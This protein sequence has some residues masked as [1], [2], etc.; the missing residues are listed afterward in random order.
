MSWP[1]R[2]GLV[3]VS[4]HQ[5]PC[6][7]H[8]ALGSHPAASWSAPA[9]LTTGL[10]LQMYFSTCCILFSSLA[11]LPRIR[12]ALV[13]VT[14][15]DQFGDP[16][17]G[18]VIQYNP[19]EAW[20]PGQTCSGCTAKPAPA[21]NAHNGTWTDAT[22]FPAGTGIGTTNVSGQIISASVPFV[23]TAVYVSVILTGSITSPDG[24]SDFTFL[25]D[26]ATAG[27]FQKEPNGDSS[28]QFNQIVFSQTGLENQLHTITIQSGNGGKKSIVLLDSIIYTK[29]NASGTDSNQSPSATQTPDSSSTGSKSSNVGV[30]VGPVVGGV[31]VGGAIIALIFFLRR[32]RRQQQQQGQNVRVL[33]DSPPTPAMRRDP[34]G[35]GF[36]NA[37]SH[38]EPFVT[39]GSQTPYKHNNGSYVIA[40][41]EYG[42][43]AVTGTH[44]QRGHSPP[45]HPGSSEGGESIH[46]VAQPRTG[47]S[48]Y[49]DVD[50]SA[51]DSTTPLASPPAYSEVATSGSSAVSRLPNPYGKGNRVSNA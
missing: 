16:T 11:L 33:I 43:T 8:L 3:L 4:S 22:F 51:I 25:I 7:E 24:R 47:A 37:M 5:L 30:I 10:A 49:G 23:G 1:R 45:T 18:Q 20:N 26:N 38:V 19:P 35:T 27:V 42:G 17:T 29:K 21:S 48:A 28:Y 15:D 34:A 44:I 50:E 12:G 31:I 2:R 14:I 39:S 40:G 6:T 9:E 13:N 41:P 36:H 46:L 32:R